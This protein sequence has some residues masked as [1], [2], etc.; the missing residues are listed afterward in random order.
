MQEYE[1]KVRE[2]NACLYFVG[3]DNLLE[4]WK[5][6]AMVQ[7]IRCKCDSLMK[8]VGC[9]VQNNLPCIY[10]LKLVNLVVN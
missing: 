1:P 9:Y 8:F 2:K 6:N 3:M 7:A 10:E 4:L 5:G